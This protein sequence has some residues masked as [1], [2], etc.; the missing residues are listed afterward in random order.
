MS[1]S[2]KQQRCLLQCLRERS[3][4]ALTAGEL[5]AQL[6]RAGV[7]I[8]LATIYRQLEK[9]EAQGSIHKIRTEEGA[10]YQYCP[11]GGQDEDSVLLR[12]RVCGRVQHLEC[13]QIQSLR[14]HL[15]QDHQFT[16]DTRD[17]VLMGLCAQCAAKEECKH[18]P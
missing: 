4:E 15:A 9:L 17:T 8:G 10:C 5:S 2:T 14:R 7:S 11:N 1:Y 12:C 18:E 16:I 13:Q 3:D 6:H